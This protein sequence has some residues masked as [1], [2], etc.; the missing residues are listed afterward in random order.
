MYVYCIQSIFSYIE[1]KILDEN[2]TVI[3]LYVTFWYS[4]VDY[5]CEKI[6]LLFL[7][8]KSQVFESLVKETHFFK[9]N[10]DDIMF[11]IYW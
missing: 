8:T 1:I 5:L 3:M 6:S 11:C 7:L 4:K 10:K 9:A 2:Q